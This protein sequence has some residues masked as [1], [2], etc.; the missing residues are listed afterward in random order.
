MVTFSF[1]FDLD[2]LNIFKI[3]D[4]Y[5]IPLKSKD[6]NNKPIICAGGPVV[7][8]NPEPYKE[9]FDFFVIGDGE[10]SNLQVINVLKKNKNKSKSEILEMI[11]DI[12]GIYVPSI[13]KGTTSIKKSVVDL[14]KCIYTPIL[15]DKSFFNNTFIIEVSRG[16]YN[17]C[18]FCIAS[19]LNNPYR[20]VEYQNIINKIDLG[21]KYTNKI[22]L[23]G[24][25]VSAH[26][27][28]EKICNYIYNK[29]QSNNSI[30][31]SIS[32][33]RANSLT[34]NVVKT[35]VAAGQKNITIAI[36]AATERLRKTVNKNITEKQL[37]D[38][39]KIAK[40]NGLKGIKIYAMLGIPTETDYDVKEFVRLAKSLKTKFKNFN[41]TFAFST[42]IPKPHT[43]FQWLGR[44][45]TASLEKKQQY[46]KLGVT[47]RFSSAKWDYYQ[48]VLSK[49]DSTLTNYLIE[50]YKNGG[51][52]GAFK[53]SAKKL[54]IN[55]DYF[56]LRNSDLNEELPWN[57]I[58]VLPG[59]QLLKNEYYR[60]MKNV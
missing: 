38:A 45:N 14:D 34:E 21:L 6:R 43:P 53:N 30:E 40:D 41:L 54:N 15:S 31:M 51:K 47:A 28:F 33:M 25:L 11:A 12:E 22:A 2:F 50:V 5:N 48:A 39:I 59:V 18:G 56:A 8:A 23:L 42:F 3:L 55:T 44:E 37:F 24:A 29:I 27:D 32:S 13:H 16:C 57:F 7:T 52:L 19:Y 36:E 60:L 9:F 17:R 26:P 58:S 4:K 10:Y 35:L 1:S 46:H 20:Y 49:G